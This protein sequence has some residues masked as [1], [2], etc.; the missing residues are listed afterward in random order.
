MVKIN[1]KPQ[2]GK[3][4]KC[5]MM[6]ADSLPLNLDIWDYIQANFHPQSAITIGGRDLWAAAKQKIPQFKLTCLDKNNIFDHQHIYQ[7]AVSDKQISE[8][9]TIFQIHATPAGT[10]IDIDSDRN[11]V[12]LKNDNDIMD[13]NQK[14]LSGISAHHCR[15]IFIGFDYD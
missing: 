3:G 10:I 9:G 14:N 1:A 13:F 7:H 5:T 6:P 2:K 15:A 11:F 8:N 4:A 12:Q